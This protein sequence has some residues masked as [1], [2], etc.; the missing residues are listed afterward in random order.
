MK[1]VRPIEAT[2]VTGWVHDAVGDEIEGFQLK[3]IRSGVETLL[4]ASG[5]SR[6]IR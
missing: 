6:E 4:A 1:G 3:R 5:I 2:T